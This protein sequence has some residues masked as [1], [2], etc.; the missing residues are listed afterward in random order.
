MTT[1]RTTSRRL[2]RSAAS[3]RP[4]PP[5]RTAKSISIPIA[6]PDLIKPLLDQFTKETGI[7]TNVLF[8][9]KGLVERIQAEGE[10][11]PADVILTVDIARLTEA[12]DGGVTQAVNERRH[13]QGHPRP[14]TATPTATGSA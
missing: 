13:R 4:C 9:D 12:K 7:A 2:R 8:L 5:W 6:Q 3:A 10:N 11:S 1:L 14:T